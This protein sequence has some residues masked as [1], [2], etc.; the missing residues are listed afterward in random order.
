MKN[1]FSDDSYLLLDGAMGTMLQQRGLKPGENPVTFHVTHPELVEDV[2]RQYAEMGSRVLL[3]NT[4]GASR[5]K[6]QGTGYTVEQVIET[7]VHVAKRGAN[8]TNALV[9]LDIG[10][11]GEFLAPVGTL[12][13]DEAY[14]LF[15]EQ[16]V[17]G[18]KAGADLVFIETMLDLQEVQAAVMAVKEN[19]SL[20]IFVT[21]TFSANGRTLFGHQPEEF[22]AAV[23][24]MGV[25]A[26]GLNCS[27][28]PKEMRDTVSRI[29]GATNLPVIVKP[30]AGLPNP[31]TGAYDMQPEEFAQA[32][33]V[34]VE[35]GGTI[36]G[37]CCGTSPAYIAALR[38]CLLKPKSAHS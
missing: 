14:A 29:K 1:L 17:A 36:L 27:T 37:G 25:R 34:L 35:S 8:G 31:L 2:H 12:I 11:L 24:D 26:V 23:S 32:M 3:T 9:A 33:E 30:N 16:A 4:F 10:P 7:A 28:G 38:D 22:A 13:F 20:P 19:T 21:M 18:S 5:S 6:L 15:R